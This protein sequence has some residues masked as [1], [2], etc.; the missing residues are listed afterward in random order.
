MNRLLILCHLALG[1]AMALLVIL[2]APT[3]RVNVL[4]TLGGFMIFTGAALEIRTRGLANAMDRR[5]DERERARRDHAHRLAY[6]TLSFPLGCLVGINLHRLPEIMDAGFAV[7]PEAMPTFLVFCWL[8]VALFL[9]LP[10]AI[11]AWTEPHPLDDDI[12][13]G[14]PS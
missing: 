14:E 4:M 11:I 10:T 9:S 8:A 2:D 13:Q 12:I 6:W 7:S 1:I 5:T 3:A